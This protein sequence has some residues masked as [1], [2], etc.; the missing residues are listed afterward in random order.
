[1]FFFSLVY[2]LSLKS[3]RHFLQHVTRIDNNDYIT[4]MIDR[5]T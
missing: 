1:M 4:N 2:W 3:W 5:D